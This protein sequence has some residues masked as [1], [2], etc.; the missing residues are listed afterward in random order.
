MPEHRRD[1]PLPANR[2]GRPIMRAFRDVAVN[3]FGVFELS[4]KAAARL[5]LAAERWVLLPKL[6]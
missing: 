1:K 2:S 4:E 6:D 3:S 5:V